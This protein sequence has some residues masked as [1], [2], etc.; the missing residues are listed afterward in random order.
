MSAAQD[1]GVKDSIEDLLSFSDFPGFPF[2]DKTWLGIFLNRDLYGAPGVPRAVFD[3]LVFG[4]GLRGAMPLKFVPALTSPVGVECFPW[5]E[6]SD[7]CDYVKFIDRIDFCPEYYLVS[8]DFSVLLW[9]DPEAV[10]VG[11]D[12]S[13][14]SEVAQALGGM[15]CLA[16]QSA[17]E[18]GVELDDGRSDVA[19][20]IREISGLV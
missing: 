19:A 12:A 13:L 3:S 15:E 5:T 1:G 18:F 10:V 20:F 16:Q 14:I 6:L 4:L 2:K 17:R 11:G 7:W 9:F 8:R